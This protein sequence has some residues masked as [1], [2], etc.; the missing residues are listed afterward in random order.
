M[1][2]RREGI[3]FDTR[4]PYLGFRCVL[5]VEG[6]GNALEPSTA[7]GANPANAPAPAGSAVPF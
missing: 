1:V 7:P 4:L 2:T 3:K 6:P 5:P